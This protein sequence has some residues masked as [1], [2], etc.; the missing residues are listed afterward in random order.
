MVST[1]PANFDEYSDGSNDLLDNEKPFSF[2]AIRNLRCSHICP[3]SHTVG[4]GGKIPIYRNYIH[5]LIPYLHNGVFKR[6][7]KR[8]APMVL[9]T[10]SAAW[11]WNDRQ[12]S[13]PVLRRNPNN[14]YLA[15]GSNS[16]QKNAD[17]TSDINRT[18]RNNCAVPNH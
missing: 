10:W 11:N 14:D 1:R 8:V 5:L 13:A 17:R 16:A 15:T 4:L 7:E 12:I 3:I 18:D 6:L 9:A 2:A